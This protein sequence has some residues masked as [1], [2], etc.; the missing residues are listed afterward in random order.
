[1]CSNYKPPPNSPGWYIKGLKRSVLSLS[2]NTHLTDSIRLHLHRPRFISYSLIYSWMLR[3]GSIISSFRGTGISSELTDTKA[4][5]GEHLN[6]MEYDEPGR[7]K[8][9]FSGIRPKGGHPALAELGATRPSLVSHLIPF[10]LKQGIRDVKG[11]FGRNDD[12][13]ND[14]SLPMS[15][16]GT[17]RNAGNR[18]QRHESR[19]LTRMLSGDSMDIDDSGWSSPPQQQNLSAPNWRGSETVPM[20]VDDVPSSSFAAQPPRRQ[21]SMS[22][23]KMSSPLLSF[24][25]RLRRSPTQMSIDEEENLLP[26]PQVDLR[27]PHPEHTLSFSQQAEA[28]LNDIILP[29]ANSPEEL[30]SGPQYGK[31][32]HSGNPLHPASN[33]RPMTP[34]PAPPVLIDD[35]REKR[36]FRPTRKLF[37]KIKDL[38]DILSRSRSRNAGNGGVGKPKPYDPPTH[39]PHAGPT[40]SQEPPTGISTPRRT[41]LK[42]SRTGDSLEL[43]REGFGGNPVNQTPADN[44]RPERRLIKR[45]RLLRPQDGG[46]S[47]LLLAPS[48]PIAGFPPGDEGRTLSNPGPSNAIR[49]P[50]PIMSIHPDS[51]SPPAKDTGVWSGRLRRL[52]IHQRLGQSAL[53]LG[54]SVGPS[55]RPP[56]SRYNARFALPPIPKRRLSSIDDLSLPS[57][58]EEQPR[59]GKD[60]HH[61]KKAAHE[62]RAAAAAAAGAAAY[63]KAQINWRSRRGQ[64]A[65]SEPPRAHPSY[66]DLPPAPQLPVISLDP[67]PENS[68]GWQRSDSPEPFHLDDSK[69]QV[70]DRFPDAPSIHIEPPS[71]TE[72]VKRP[73]RR[74][75]GDDVAGSSQS[76]SLNVEIDTGDA[77]NIS[78]FLAVPPLDRHSTAG[79]LGS[80]TEDFWDALRGITFRDKN[81]RSTN[82][83]R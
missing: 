58:F 18:A 46:P 56:V 71:R 30:P 66:M 39:S 81:S 12:F 50:G 47:S 8:R 44:P 11:L 5:V 20:D 59:R 76:P 82:T 69:P 62:R 6:A 72:S 40:K 32:L 41:F 68:L 21:D 61:G 51:E 38:R 60:P 13:S 49:R 64:R 77:N 42:R 10:D 52:P 54:R 26:A 48:G 31:K 19:G 78:N 83:S 80:F 23:V 37:D 73:V 9:V 17:T 22:S 34:L 65:S 33:P 7:F 28:L 4:D 27:P 14:K 24:V 70:P 16:S 29:K 36:R 3:A 2:Y 45:P 1:M 79:A 74:A 43:Y 15:P 35:R 57:P 67:L 53:R 55:N 75:A 25:K 63:K